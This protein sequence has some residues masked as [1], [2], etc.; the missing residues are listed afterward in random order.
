MKV[1]YLLHSTIQGG[2]TISFMNMVC[3]LVKEGVVPVII[4]PHNENDIFQSFINRFNIKNYEIDLPVCIFQKPEKRDGNI[5]RTVKSRILFWKQNIIANRKIQK[6]CEKECPDII[7]TNTGVVHIGY[8]VAKANKIPHVW[9]LREY[10]DADFNWII[11]P[12][13]EKFEKYLRDG[14]V[15]S[16][17]ED[18]LAHFSLKDYSK[19]LC[20]YNGCMS[21]DSIRF[22]L[23][24]EKYFLCANRISPEKSMEDVISSFGSFYRTNKEYKLVICGFGEDSYIEKL[25]HL[26]VSVCCS[27]AIVWKGFVKDPSE[28]MSKASALIVASKSE[29]FGR[30]TAEACLQGCLVIGRNTAGTKEILDKTGGFLFDTNADLTNNLH[31]IST[32]DQDEYSKKALSAQVVAKDLY[33]IES[34][35]QK[36]SLLYKRILND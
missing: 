30:M 33:S 34:N 13:K 32:L 36:I 3:G 28:L 7:H 5:L 16:I 11:Y 26:A 12:T 31:Y 1:L 27:D 15:I 6:I 4:H 19:A 21:K 18:I 24:K 10:Q 14:Y 35:I 17:T 2:A 8:K 20:I 25:K 9:H 22:I 23:P 29:G